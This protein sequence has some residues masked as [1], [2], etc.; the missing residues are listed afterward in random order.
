MTNNI[1]RRV[2]EHKKGKIDGFSKKY[3]CNK[4]IYYEYYEYVYNA[5]DREK[6]IKKWSRKKKEVLIASMNPKWNDLYEELFS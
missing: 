6:E 4:L 1:L 2:R 3:S 5:I